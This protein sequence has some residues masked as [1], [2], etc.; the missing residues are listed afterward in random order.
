VGAVEATEVL[1]VLHAN[2]ALA[3]RVVKGL[4]RDSLLDRPCACAQACAT[5]LLT[6]RDAIPPQRLAALSILFEP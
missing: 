3:Q 1:A 5:A 2:V 4:V 6:P